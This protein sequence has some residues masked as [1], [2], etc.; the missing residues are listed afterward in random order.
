MT[1]FI[2]KIGGMMALAAL[3]VASFTSCSE[4]IDDSNLYTFTGQTVID[5][6]RTWCWLIAKRITHCN[7]SCKHTVG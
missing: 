7:G 3:G 4:E 5:Y 1:K 2:H 6:L